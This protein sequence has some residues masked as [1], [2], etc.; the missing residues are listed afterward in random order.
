MAKLSLYGY[1]PKMN[2]QSLRL[3]AGGGG[4]GGNAIYGLYR[5]VPL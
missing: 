1:L 5:Y 4:G 3:P 2:P